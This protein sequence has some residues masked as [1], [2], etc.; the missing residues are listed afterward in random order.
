[1]IQELYKSLERPYATKY[2]KI[3]QNLILFNVLVNIFVSFSGNIFNFS[4][5]VKNTFSIIEYITVLI[6][7]LELIA[8][9]IS[10]GFDPRY[11]GLK[12][13]LLYT[14][15]PFIIIDILTLVPYF[16]TNVQGGILL[17][18]LVRFFRFFRILKLVRLRDTIKQFFSVSTFATSS[19][20]K[21]FIVLFILSSVFIALFSFVYSNGEKTS[22]MIF[23]DPPALAETAT[24]TEMVF[25][26]IELLLGLFIGGALISII[27]ELL[28]NIS[29]EIKNGYYP[30]KNK[31]HIVI[32]N[33]NQKLK[34]ILKE[35]NYYYKDI[36]QL[37]DVVLFLPFVENIENFAQNLPKYSNLKV[38]LLTGDI[39]NWN[40]YERLNINFADKIVILK[41]LEK[42]IDYLDIK[43]SKYL[44]SHH[45]FINKNVSFLIESDES[46]TTQIVYDEIFSDI[47]TYSI[48]N[49]NSIIEKFLNRSIVEPNYFKIYSNLL[50]FEDSEF[51][52]LDFS[53]VFQKELTF[54]EAYIRFTDGVLIGALKDD[55][56]I[57]N[58]HKDLILSE[59]T[60]LITILKNRLEYSTTDNQY[61][62][63]K[64]IIKLTTPNLKINRNI[65]II[66]DYN[67]IQSNQIVDFLT[68]ESIENLNKIVLSDGDYLKDD[69][70][71]SKIINKNYDMIIFN[72]EDD[73]EFILTM[74][75][76]NKYKKNKKFLNSLVN[77]IHNPMNAKLLS[78]DKFYNNII[79][80]EKLV[81][82]YATQVLFNPTVIQIFEEITHSQGNEFYLLEKDN[83]TNLFK[84]NHEQ[85][86]I[87]LLEN[88]MIYIGGIVENEFIVNFENISKSQKIVV[89][90]EGI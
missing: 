56:V 17:A 14:F 50:T 80:S 68:K 1:M 2:G 29:S 89:L 58:P 53:E 8:R 81:G 35:M 84:M 66:G 25:G 85:L 20:I 70:W 51:Y 38:I 18:R 3:V 65:V 9:Y 73:E 72:L 26:I 45:N 40:S 36:E 7:I 30:Y 42:K 63:D 34:F 52:D 21:Q 67:D 31:N 10:I 43:V 44:T 22:L 55:K 54:K 77:I 47:Y 4:Y 11:S 5:A 78:D 46:K 69:F 49:H 75:L 61:P 57:L 19:I 74:Y 64:E 82:E 28:T 16:L 71:D 48:I 83:Y 13:R 32:I 87:T 24:D 37:K 39:L 33:H 60:K 15:T 23:L 59:D 27:T 90:T 88:K 79:L 12:G 62:Q 6:F 41:Q 76:R 86:K